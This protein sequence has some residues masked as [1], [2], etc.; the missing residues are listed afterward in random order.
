MHD[1]HG[2]RFHDVERLRSQEHVQRL[3]VSRVVRLALEDSSI[4]SLLDIGTGSGIFAEAF[5]KQ[6]L[7]VTGIDANPEMLDAAWSHL[8][9][10]DFKQAAAEAIPFPD[11]SFDLAFMGLV[12]H[13]TDDLLKAMQEAGRVSRVRLVVLEWP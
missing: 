4:K 6:G 10:A 3:E 9:T 1:H 13:E 5:A 12:L 2:N 7:T 11:S 8:P